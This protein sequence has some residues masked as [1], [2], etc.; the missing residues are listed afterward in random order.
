MYA[1]S[2]KYKQAIRS[3][4]RK[5]YV[6]GTLT[7]GDIEYPLND[8]NI[9][10]DSLYITNQMINDNKLCFGAV[11]AG[12]CGLTINSSIDRYKLYGAKIVLNYAL[13]IEDEQQS[14]MEIVPLGEFYVDT[15][16]RIGSTIKLTAVDA[17]S[18][19]DKPLQENINGTLYELIAYI[20]NK[21][22]V[23]LAQTEEEILD[24]HANAT[25]RTYTIRQEFISTYRDALAYLAMIICSN[26]TIDRHGRLKLV[27]YATTACDYNDKD[28]RITNC[29]F[30]D[31]TTQYSCI[32]ARFYAEEAYAPY[33]VKD[34]DI[35][36]LVLD[37][38]D[39]SIVG[40][41]PAE[42]YAVLNAMLDTLKQIV[43]VPTTLYI[44]S[45][46]AYDL[47]DMIECRN[48][49]NSTDSVNMYV[50]QYNFE[51]RNKETINCYGENPLLQ[52]I[53]SDTDKL[54]SSFENQLSTKNMI[55]VNYTNAQEYIIG[56]TDHTIIT[57]N[58]IFEST[59]KPIIICTIPFTIDTDGYV[60][61]SLDD[62][63]VAMEDATY[64]GYYEKGSHFATFLYLDDYERGERRN[65][66]VLARTYADTSSVVRVHDAQIRALQQALNMDVDN[67]DVDA[68]EPTVII[69]IGTIKAIAYANAGGNGV[70]N[71]D[72]TLEFI[73]EFEAISVYVPEFAQFIADVVS[74]MRTPTSSRFLEIFT[75][76]N[77]A[78]IRFDGT[79]KSW[80]EYMNKTWGEVKLLAW[81]SV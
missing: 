71:W 60:E 54:V 40:G 80:G 10:K 9:I 50:M 24:M 21:C 64:R 25:G 45:N 23:E 79:N 75:E 17:M 18:N 34:D 22:G 30:S 11:Y 67:T 3:N 76:I 59:C 26:A 52:N 72:G 33:S 70:V 32:T 66:K 55:I 44:P 78:V 42:K 73:D 41:T 63:F 56:Q 38:G 39:I 74:G 57:L 7:V 8:D 29:E 5:G 4:Q 15:P 65:L 37:L 27:Q 43:Y 49:N 62:G 81:D 51:Y 47:G 31:Y 36:G 35:N 1:V 68:T 28:T 20:S 19:F 14:T 12:E 69:E 61:F 46:P 53:K 13:E 2:D 16:K 48:I 58:Y 6:F 77:T